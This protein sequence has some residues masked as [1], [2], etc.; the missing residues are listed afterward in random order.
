MQKE[1]RTLYNQIGKYIFTNI[2]S[3][4]HLQSLEALKYLNPRVLSGQNNI[5][6]GN[7]LIFNT[8]STVKPV[9]IGKFGSTELSAVRKYLEYKNSPNIEEMTRQNRYQIYYASGLFPENMETYI[10]YCEHLLNLTLSQIDIFAVWFNYGEH[11]ILKKYSPHSKHVSLLSLESYMEID[12]KK[13]W[14]R[15]LENKKVL[16]ISPFK[17]T[18]L[19]QYNK[20]K[21]IWE[22]ENYVLPDFEAY[23]IKAPFQPAVTKAIKYNSYFEALDDMKSQMT[24]MDFD[25]ALIGAGAYS[26]PLC[27]YAKSLGK[28]AIHLGGSLQLYFGINGN[29]WLENQQIMKYVND[30]W[31]RPLPEETPENI[32]IVENGCYW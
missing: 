28:Q 12:D 32:S 3:K 29:R 26:L 18:I 30:A 24:N 1:F 23:F 21:Y 10:R 31:T 22:N 15:Y 2:L 19:M 20:R 6:Y 13:R 27:A 16:I 14:T 17:E 11:R 5:T 8:L 7:Q 9:A 4:K 25:I